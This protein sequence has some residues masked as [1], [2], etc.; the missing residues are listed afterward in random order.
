MEINEETTKGCPDLVR[1]PMN[2]APKDNQL[3]WLQF[4]KGVGAQHFIAW[5][6]GENSPEKPWAF[7]EYE[8]V[9]NTG[10]RIN[11]VVDSDTTTWT[12]IGNYYGDTSV[13]KEIQIIGMLC[14]L[15]YDSNRRL[16]WWRDMFPC[17]TGNDPKSYADMYEQLQLA[18]AEKAEL[19]R[20]CAEIARLYAVSITTGD[21][22]VWR[23]Q[24]GDLDVMQAILSLLPKE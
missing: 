14:T 20:Q 22:R 15:L 1:L 10:Y 8:P 12:P 9:N 18:Q 3:F 13:E 5:W 16:E 11:H 21:G 4:G 6:D 7:L 23:H 2:I 24:Y 17:V 19:V